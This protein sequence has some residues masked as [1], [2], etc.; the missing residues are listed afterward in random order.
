M[1]WDASYIVSSSL[2]FEIARTGALL[3]ANSV[4]RPPQEMADDALPVLRA[5]AAGATPRAALARLREEWELDDEGFA[6]VVER[7]LELNFLTPVRSGRGEAAV[8]LATGGFASLISHHHMLRDNVRVMSYRA[9]IHRHCHDKVVVEV[10]CGTGILSIFAA[11]AGARRVIA[12]EES[13]IAEVAERM[14]RANGCDGVVELVRANSRDV[15]LDEPADVVIHE[16]LGVDPFDE[17]ILPFI[18]DA[19]QRFLCPG[20]RLLPHRLEVF[21]AGVE[22]P[23]KNFRDHARM[24]A[25]ARELGGMYGVDFS[26]FQEALTALDAGFFLP[27]LVEP[28]TA[29]FDLRI[30]SAEVR[31]V[32]VDFAAGLPESGLEPFEVRLPIVGEGSLG[33]VVLYFRAHLDETLTVTNSPFAP[34]TSWGWNAQ[35]LARSVA[36]AAGD[37]VRLSVALRTAFGRQGLRVELADSP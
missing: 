11:Q 35:P 9:A 36:V 2:T 23:K 25:E 37:E 18:R 15:E 1:D 24:L 27:R 30:L 6:A 28:G 13:N 34:L 29:T 12:I 7:M 5:F 33:G 14:L 16:I 20:G 19:R 8:A 17:G 31:L 26:P 4:S 22:A 32:D 3:A 10:G 21:C